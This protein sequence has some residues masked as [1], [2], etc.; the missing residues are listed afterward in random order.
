MSRARPLET[1]LAAVAVLVASWPVRTLLI[2]DTWI[3]PVLLL[4]ALVAVIGMVGRAVGAPRSLTAAAQLVGVLG[5]TA[6]LH[7]HDHLAP[8]QLP[9]AIGDLF[10]D[11]TNTLSRYAAPAP[12]TPGIV[13]ALTLIVPLVAVLV[14]LMSVGMRM[15]ALAGMP[16]LAL[17]L[18]STSNTGEPLNPVYFVALAAAWLLMLAQG[19]M[20]LLRRWSSTEAYSRTPERLED[21]FGIAGYSST[22]RWVGAGTVLL[23]ILVPA[24]L[25]H[26]PP[27]YLSDGLARSGSGG[28]NVGVVGFS[29]RLDLEQNLRSRS[30]EPVLRYTTSDPD[31]PPLRAMSMSMYAGGNWV[32]DDPPRERRGTNNERLPSPDGLGSQPITLFR[33]KVSANGVDSP[34]VAV[35]WPVSSA[36]MGDTSWTYEPSA[37]MPRVSDRP[38]SYQIT[39]S[40]LGPSARPNGSH[41]SAPAVPSNTLRVDPL[42]A[43]RVQQTA[44]GIVRS[45]DSDFTKAIKI[46]DWLRDPSRF[47]Y[48]L[49]LKPTQVVN[50]APLDPISN[51]LVTR[52]GYCTQFATAMVMLARSQDIPARLAVGFLPGTADGQSYQVRQ[53]DAHAWPELYFPGLGWTRFEPTPGVRAGTVPE[54]AGGS[55]S[56]SGPG[57]G[58]ESQEATD[59]RTSTAPPTPTA[60]SADTRQTGGGASEQS[61]LSSSTTWWTL[62]VLVVGA[63]GALVVPVAARWRREQP[64]RRA[65]DGREHVEG[66]WHALQSRLE[67]LGVAPPAGRTPRQAEQHYRQHATLGGEGRAA[68]HRAVRT[69]EASRYAE[70]TTSPETLEQDADRI[71]R[72]VR[73]NASWSVRTAALLAPRTGRLAVRSGLRAVLSAPGRWLDRRGRS[74]G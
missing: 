27:R 40:K 23:A 38:D 57:A 30:Q 33:T 52:Q 46:Q 73:G 71:L 25:P 3:R 34:F 47:T 51:F 2:G 53:S 5:G 50:G 36:D 60:P 21:R 43:D 26:L 72:D 49:T 45:N 15:P 7:L 19:G 54:Y 64:L 35:P 24:F 74:G 48:S 41:A 8:S 11:A 18:M 56:T 69:L 67:D 14:D 59:T 63:L 29:D 68:L 13:F 12:A 62:L 17:F 65:Q 66:E 16:L 20:Q 6:L 58:R 39:Y 37:A 42:S 4:L 55:S 61:W 32:H 1:L 31:P 70:P 10:V 44:D 28:G 9:G 22:A